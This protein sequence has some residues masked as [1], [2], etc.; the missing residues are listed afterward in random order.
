MYVANYIERN[1]GRGSLVISGL[2]ARTLSTVDVPFV[3]E[4]LKLALM[5][6]I[7]IAEI[8]IINL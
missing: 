3:I 1:F 8:F 6:K 4:A 7:S 5:K 2:M